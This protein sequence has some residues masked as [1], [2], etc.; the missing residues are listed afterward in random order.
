MHLH[1][2]SGATRKDDS[3]DTRGDEATTGIDEATVVIKVLVEVDNTIAL[4]VIGLALLRGH[5]DCASVAIALIML[6]LCIVINEL[7][8]H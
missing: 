3:G 4:D 7:N 5:L 2:M 6:Q 8:V 1:R